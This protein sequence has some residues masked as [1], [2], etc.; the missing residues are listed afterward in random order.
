M[1]WTQQRRTAWVL[2]LGVCWLALP[3]RA[4]AQPPADAP[5]V[6]LSAQQEGP[7]APA[8]LRLSERE[9]FPRELNAQRIRMNWG[10]VGLLTGWTLANFVVG[11]LGWASADDATWRAFHQMNVLFNLPIL[12]TAVVSALVLREQDPARLT[13]QESLRR[14]LKLERA[15]L[16]GMA[17]DLVAIAT[18]AW[19]WERGLRK[20]S[21]RLVG[22]GR[23]FM[24]QGLVLLGFDS[25]VFLLNTR[26]D[27]RLLLRVPSGERDATGLALH[28]RF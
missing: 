1:L 17:L 2:L 20:D 28:V 10:A 19:L 6:F 7:G 3:P 23:S 24:L 18:G 26:Y 9:D 22:W 25:T 12:G 4:A 27:A 14:G 15:L 8:R 13:L 5:T 16:V 21:E 11:G